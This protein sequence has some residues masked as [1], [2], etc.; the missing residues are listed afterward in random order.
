LRTRQQY[1]AQNP[2]EIRAFD[3]KLELRDIPGKS[4]QR[5]W[6]TQRLRRSIGFSAIQ[7]PARDEIVRISLPPS[8]LLL[9]SASDLA[10]RISTSSLTRTNS[11]IGTE[12]TAAN[13]AGFLSGI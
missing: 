5:R 3:P 6:Q 10:I 12:P 13:A 11:R 9:L 1:L 2:N 8:L 4:A 7:N